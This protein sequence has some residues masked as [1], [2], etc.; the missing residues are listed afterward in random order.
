MARLLTPHLLAAIELRPRLEKRFEGCLPRRALSSLSDSHKRVSGPSSRSELW[1]C[2]HTAR[3]DRSR[4]PRGSHATGEVPYP[5]RPWACPHG[6]DPV[7]PWSIDAQ[8]LEPNWRK[9]PPVQEVP[10]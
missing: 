9:G 7:D 8:W 5:I 4:K 3:G 2:V 1:P 10:G 6:F